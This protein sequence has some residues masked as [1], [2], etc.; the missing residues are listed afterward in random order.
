MSE[1]IRLRCYLSTVLSFP[2]KMYESGLIGLT[3]VILKAHAEASPVLDY[4]GH[5][6]LR[7]VNRAPACKRREPHD[8]S[9][10]PIGHIRSQ[11]ATSL[12]MIAIALL[13]LAAWPLFPV[14]PLPQV[15]FPTISVSAS[16]PRRKSGDH[17]V[18]RRATIRA[19][20]R[21]RSPASRRVRQL[22]RSDRPRSRCSSN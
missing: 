8:L 17:G 18:R 13:G 14:A 20:V 12:L 22:A 16:A 4:N 21:V 2:K 9:K 7:E 3:D 6:W 10:S 11:D 1:Q 5:W 15:D 19:A